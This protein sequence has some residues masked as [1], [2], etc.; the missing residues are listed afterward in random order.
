VRVERVQEISAVDVT[1][2]GY[3]RKDG[4]LR[5]QY[6][7]TWNSI[8]GDGAWERNDWVWVIEFSRHDE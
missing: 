1:A 8:H 2:L 4:V 3:N 5:S 7:T 6:R